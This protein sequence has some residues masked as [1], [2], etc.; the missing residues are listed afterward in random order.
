MQVIF[1][2]DTKDTKDTK[3]IE[4]TGDAEETTAFSIAAGQKR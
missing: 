1:T 4:D 3:N 2:T